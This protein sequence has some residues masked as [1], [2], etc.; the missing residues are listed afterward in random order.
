MDRGSRW[1]R[2]LPGL[3]WLAVSTGHAE[4]P[5][6]DSARV[7]ESPHLRVTVALAGGRVASLVDKANGRDLVALWRGSD[8][9]GGLLDDRQRFTRRRYAVVPG[10]AVPGQGLRLAAIDSGGQQLEKTFSL[11]ADGHGLRVDY[12][13]SNG[14]QEPVRLWVRSFPLPGGAPLSEHHL[15]CL[16]A[17]PGL[18]RQPFASEYFGGLAAPWAALHDTVTGQGVLAVV[19]GVERFYFWQ[20]SRE[21]PTFEW[22]YPETPPGQQLRVSLALCVLDA[23]APDWPRYAGEVLAGLP[24]PEAAPVVGWVDARQRLALPAAAQQRGFWLSTG[25][26]QDRQ[27]LPDTVEVDLPRDG[28]RAWYVGVNALAGANLDTV[29]ARV[30]GSLAGHVQ[31]AWES[32]QPQAIVVPVGSAAAGTRPAPGSES[33][34]WLLFSAAGL[35]PGVHLGEL[36]IG[37]NRQRQGVPLRLRVWPVALPALRPFDMRGYATLGDLTGSYQVT[38]ASCRQLDALL[39]AYAALGGSVLDWTVSWPALLPQIRVRPAG[40]VPAVAP[41]TPVGAT[42]PTAPGITPAAARA[43]GA[44][45]TAAVSPGVAMVAAIPGGAATGDGNIAAPTLEQVAAGPPGGLPRDRLPGLDFSAFD[46]WLAVARKHGVVRVETYLDMAAGGRWPWPCLGADAVAGGVDDAVTVWLLTQLR[47]YLEGQGCRGFFCKIGDEI[48]PEDLPA[49]QRA[50][51]LARRA[52]WRPFT[53][54]TGLVARDALSLDRMD[55]DCDQWQVSVSLKDDFARWHGADAT[56]EVWFYG[57]GSQPFR[58][59]YESAVVYP[60]LAAVEGVQGYGWWAYYWWQETEKIVWYDAATSAVTCGPAYLGLRDGWEDA[61]LYAWVVNQRHLIPTAAAAGPGE[62][63]LLRLAPASWEVY[64]WT[65]L[66][67]LQ[68]PVAI[69]RVRRALL[70]AAAAAP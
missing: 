13:F 65:T 1:L 16:P 3:F 11:L 61:R 28:Q 50:A 46:P 58:T 22:L 54:I 48:S 9:I 23:A 33:R 21:N 35:S 56:D 52:G 40:G 32:Q 24:A 42:P 39:G 53:T 38:P 70:A 19:P 7:L 64:R 41:A 44:A 5:S 31:I 51:A 4:V 12:V 10:A 34:L 59:A 55:P 18:L 68:S 57:G 14:G 30:T 63:T 43:K 69:N 37:G 25:R 26:D 15:Y 62:G 29:V 8:E 20:G 66:A 27:V 45:A 17:A 67:G 2:A 36:E 6:I 47:T 60:L 49:Y